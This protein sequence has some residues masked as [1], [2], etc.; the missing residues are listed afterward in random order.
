MGVA[1]VPTDDETQLPTENKYNTKGQGGEAHAKPCLLDQEASAF[2]S[3]QRDVYSLSS[4]TTVFTL[5]QMEGAL[6]FW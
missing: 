2:G 3:P 5:F 6:P 4:F 1:V